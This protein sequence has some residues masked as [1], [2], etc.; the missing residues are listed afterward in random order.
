MLPVSYLHDL[1]FVRGKPQ[2]L[3]IDGAIL[4]I[5]FQLGGSDLLLAYLFRFRQCQ[6]MTTNIA[7][8]GEIALGGLIRIVRAVERPASHTD[9]TAAM[10]AFADDRLHIDRSVI[11]QFQNGRERFALFGYKT[12]K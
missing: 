4:A 2:S 6:L 3:A 5:H 7:P 1:K 9:V 10:G 11:R 8:D 12:V